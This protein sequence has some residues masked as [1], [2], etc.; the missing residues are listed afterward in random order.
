MTTSTKPKVLICATPVYGHVMPL[1]AVARGLIARGYDVTYVTKSEFRDSI[2]GI[3]A[4]F[5]PLRG[6][7]DLNE[8]ILELFHDS[9]P[10]DDPVVRDD[11]Y[12]R[13]FVDVIP[14]QHEGAQEG[15]RMILEKQPG[16][17]VVVLYEGAFKGVLPGILGASGTRPAGYIG[18]GILPVTLSSIDLKPISGVGFYPD[19]TP[20]G[21]ARNAELTRKDRERWAGSQRKFEEVLRKMGATVPDVFHGDANYTCPDR[22]IQMCAPSIEFPRSDAPSGFR[23]AGGL[24]PGL[25]DPFVTF[26]EWWDD[27]KV[28][29]AKRKII[30]VSQGTMSTESK[31]LILPTMHAFKDRKDVVV[32]VAL[33][34]KGST[35]PEGTLVP[36]N[37]RVSDWI[38]FDEML[39]HTDIMVTN[40]GYGAV[41]HALGH[42]VPLIVA[43]VGAD[44]PDNALRVHWAEVGINLDTQRPTPDA[45]LQAAVEIFEDPKY[46]RKAKAVQAEMHSYD[47]I[48]V[49]I[50]NIEEVAAGI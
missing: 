27:I 39:E 10:N 24:P 49:V 37:A 19:S 15:L 14:S 33:G 50:E 38:P 21:Q 46:T 23:F 42:G 35:L 22:F 29:S 13:F 7:A 26:P 6:E 32:V 17:K 41:Q 9:S 2:E 45:V 47:P 3:S 16:S 48:G 34:K 5:I 25:R 18:V 12:R 44:K 8:E 36:E 40:G 4:S 43:G 30:F 28:N 20:E 31:D 11:I 1:R